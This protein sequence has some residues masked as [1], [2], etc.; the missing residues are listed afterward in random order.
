MHLFFEDFL[1][2]KC[3]FSFS[4]YSIT[5]KISEAVDF[6]SPKYILPIIN[7]ISHFLNVL[8]LKYVNN[9]MF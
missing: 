7:R 1:L 2:V 8:T 3:N 4:N 5:T 6:A 9:Y